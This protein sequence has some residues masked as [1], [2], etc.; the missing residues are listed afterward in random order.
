MAELPNIA[1][2][3]FKRTDL[4]AWKLLVKVLVHFSVNIKTTIIN[5]AVRMV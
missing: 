1:L 2:K 5:W 3:F 4:G